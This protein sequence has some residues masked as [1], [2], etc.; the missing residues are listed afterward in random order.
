LSCSP[1]VCVMTAA[2]TDAPLCFTY[3]V[4]GLV[5]IMRWPHP[6]F[7]WCCMLLQ[8]GLA[9]LCLVGSST[10]LV[11]AKIEANL[12]RKRGPAIAGY[13]KAWDKFMEQ[14]GQHWLK[15]TWQRLM[16]G[17]VG[18]GVV[19]QLYHAC[20]HAC[21]PRCI[22]RGYVCAGPHPSCFNMTICLQHLH[23]EGALVH[24][25][26]VSLLPQQLSLTRPWWLT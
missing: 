5:R 3:A 2:Q 22:W 21:T 11:R 20:M 25:G 14:V 16:P 26:A 23:P 15:E 19:V 18:A 12:P 8:E 4:P 17:P 1:G 13:D 6:V 24:N 7:G 10:T 9:H